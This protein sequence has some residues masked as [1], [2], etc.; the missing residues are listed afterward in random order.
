MKRKILVAVFV[1]L[2]ALVI[3]FFGILRYRCIVRYNMYSPHDAY[4][5]YFYIPGKH[6]N[7]FAEDLD[8]YG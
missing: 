2:V 6:E 8:Y 1:A 5:I 7:I 4:A 3:Y